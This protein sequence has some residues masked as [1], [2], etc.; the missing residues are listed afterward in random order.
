MSGFAMSQGKQ[1]KVFTDAQVRTALQF[2][3]SSRHQLRDKTILL[4]SIRAGLRAKEIASLSDRA[5]SNQ[6]PL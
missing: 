3:S 4:L 6:R 1:A 2:L 5:K